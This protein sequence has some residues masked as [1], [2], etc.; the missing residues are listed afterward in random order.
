MR[1]SLLTTKR[2]RERG[3][4]FIDLMVAIAVLALLTVTV[5]P[6]SNPEAGMKLISAATVLATDIEYAQSATLSEP[7]DQTV[8][9]FDADGGGYYLAKASSPLDPI[10]RPGSTESYVVRFGEGGATTLDGVGVQEAALVEPIQFDAFGSLMDDG[11]RTITLFTSLGVIQVDVA[12]STG[13][14]SIVKP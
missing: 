1:S 12:Q 13:S 5:M 6:S 3:F 4:T 8:L 10:V 11:D 9:V 2:S 14:V 7:A